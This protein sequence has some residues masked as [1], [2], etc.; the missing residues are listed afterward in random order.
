MTQTPTEPIQATLLIST[1][2]PH[3]ASLLN[4]VNQLIKQGELAELRVINLHTA[5]E[6]A[7]QF[8]VRSVPWVKIGSY[9]LSGNQPLAA[10]QQRI[11]WIR[12]QAGLVGQFDHLLSQAQAAKACELLHQQPEKM[13]AIMQLLA[14]PATVLS[15]RIGIGVV[16]E[17]FAGSPSLREYIPQLGKL[18]SHTD[19]RIRMDVAHYLSL[20][21]DAS[22][23]RLLQQQL[24]HETHEEVR[25]VIQD[26]LESLQM[27]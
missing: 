24:N 27:D 22:V 17:D 12:D 8:G 2:C 20:T 7:Q 10:L 3:C 23:L 16:M 5:P 1:H 4:S 19:A 13:T 15:T 11:Q 14:D 18:L 26:S 9:E 25:E 21:E 6:L